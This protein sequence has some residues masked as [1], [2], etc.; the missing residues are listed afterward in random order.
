MKI[1]LFLHQIWRYLKLH[2]SLSS[3]W[4]P[5]EWELNM[6]SG[7]YYC[8]VFIRLSFWRHPFTAETLMQCYISPNLMKEQTHLHGWPEGEHIFIFAWTIPLS[9]EHIQEQVHIMHTL[10][11][12][13]TTVSET[14]CIATDDISFCERLSKHLFLSSSYYPPP[15]I[16]AIGPLHLA[17]EHEQ[18]ID[19]CQKLLKYLHFEEMLVF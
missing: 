14:Y 19:F 15:S 18:H 13:C 6:S 1:Y 17:W 9:Q 2:Y 11:Y 12:L 3:E 10:T 5:S 7:V 16:K 8:D 4:V